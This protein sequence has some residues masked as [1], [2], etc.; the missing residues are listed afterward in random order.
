VDTITTVI[1]LLPLQRGAKASQY[2]PCHVVGKFHYNNGTVVKL[3]DVSANSNGMRERERERE[4]E[5]DYADA[6]RG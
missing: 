4:R 5:R 6:S 3:Q 1:S 2:T